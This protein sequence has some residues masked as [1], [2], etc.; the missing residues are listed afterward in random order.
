MTVIFDG[1]LRAERSNLGRRLVAPRSS[2]PQGQKQRKSRSGIESAG[3]AADDHKI[4]Q[5]LSAGYEVLSNNEIRQRRTTN[6]HGQQG[7]WKGEIR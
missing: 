6:P 4:Y 1:S 7:G 3:L 2:P 5:I